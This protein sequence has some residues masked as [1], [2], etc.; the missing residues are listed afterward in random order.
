M[1]LSQV[2]LSQIGKMTVTKEVQCTYRVGNLQILSVSITGIVHEKL[3]NNKYN[4][5]HCMVE[6][7]IQKEYELYNVSK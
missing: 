1:K 4:Y 3:E 6:V 7:G 5:L 2:D